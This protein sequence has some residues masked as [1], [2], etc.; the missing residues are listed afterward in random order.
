MLQRAAAT[1]VR[2]RARRSLSLGA[3]DKQ[4]ADIGGKTVTAFQRGARADQF[5][6]QNI[7]QEQLRAVFE[8]RDAIAFG[9]DISDTNLGRNQAPNAESP[10]CARPRISA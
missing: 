5:T 10:V 2:V 7:A 6:G 4:F 1:F 3:G 8:R 9:T